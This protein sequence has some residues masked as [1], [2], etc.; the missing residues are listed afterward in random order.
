[1]F[2]ITF[3]NYDNTTEVQNL[4]GSNITNDINNL[5]LEKVKAFQFANTNEQN[6]KW[7]F[8]S[9]T[10]KKAKI[11][12]NLLK[13]YVYFY[14]RPS[15][16]TKKTVGVLL[17]KPVTLAEAVKMQEKLAPSIFGNC[18]MCE[19]N[20][21][22]TASY[23]Q[24]AYI[25]ESN[26]AFSVDGDTEEK[27]ALDWELKTKL[28]TEKTASREMQLADE[29][30]DDIA[31]PILRD[32]K[33]IIAFFNGNIIF[34]EN[35]F[36]LFDPI[37]KVWLP[38]TSKQMAKLLMLKFLNNDPNAT[39][40]VRPI[41]KTIEYLCDMDSF[42]VYKNADNHNVLCFENTALIP[43]TGEEVEPIPEHH[44][45]NKINFKSDKSAQ[46]P[47][48]LKT[49]DYFF[50]FDPDR[51]EKIK[52][53]Q[54]FFGYTLTNDTSL[55]SMIILVGAGLNGKSLILKVLSALLGAGNV[56]NVSIRDFNQRFLPIQL[57]GK[58][59]NI[60]FDCDYDA[61]MK[62]EDR[63]KRMTVG[64]PIMGEE[65][66]QPAFSFEATATLWAAANM[67]PRVRNNSYGI[68][69]RIMILEFNRI[70]DKSD[71]NL[72]LFNELKEELSGILNWS[73][74]GLA[75]LLEN[76]AFTEPASSIAANTEYQLD[77]NP[78]KYFFDE[79]FELISEDS[80][81]FKSDRIKRA[82]L[83][84]EFKGFLT[85]NSFKTIDAAKFGKELKSLGVEGSK[86][87][88]D[89]FYNVR[90]IN[91]DVMPTEAA[92]DDN[93]IDAELANA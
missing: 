59:A 18:E 37:E 14:C 16:G 75:R 60:D 11:N 80:P 67:L 53:L 23:F 46:C 7:L 71:Q 24:S 27:E 44:T 56:S 32:A 5:K 17:D 43:A 74:E 57:N 90:H 61:L 22:I 54:E 81:T 38:K 69:R 48:W 77:N 49:L 1:M 50:A 45:R 2:P 4:N 68:Y 63:L 55:Q 85:E 12:L 25:N 51:I 8:F 62:T 3:V 34:T 30:N 35:R 9:S 86:S 88:N 10:D 73:L 72:N 47:K 31:D 6:T 39:K 33:K 64:D 65:K 66:N 28:V 29:Y 79:R 52:L 76:K 58:L 13:D 89:R 40:V 42:P 19:P 70:I 93:H 83:Y 15:S 26:K 36:Y 87:G 41:L 20:Y 78:T 92:N 21:T 84:N 91:H 82:D